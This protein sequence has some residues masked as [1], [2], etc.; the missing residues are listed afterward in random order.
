[1]QRGPSIE[2][3]HVWPFLD[4]AHLAEFY[5][6][7]DLYKR[8]ITI[9][10]KGLELVNAAEELNRAIALPTIFDRAT[11]T[12]MRAVMYSLHKDLVKNAG[13]STRHCAPHY[14]FTNPGRALRDNLPLSRSSASVH[15]LCT[16][17]A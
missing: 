3:S 4:K 12:N 8:L 2:E 5:F 16:P 17:Q 7:S 13:W 6:D 11:K 10:E 9:G 1:V 15:G 14:A